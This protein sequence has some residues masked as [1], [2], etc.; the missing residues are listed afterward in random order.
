MW[1]T[2]KE[3]VELLQTNHV[4]VKLKLKNH[5][6][7]PNIF[8]SIMSIFKA[9]TEE[10]MEYVWCDVVEWKQG[11]GLDYKVRCLPV[12]NGFYAKDF[13]TCDL[14]SLINVEKVEFRLLRGR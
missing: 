9:S 10:N 8:K 12:R 7:K 13:Y 2:D 4:Q 5:M 3:F 1:F 14:V 11:F 6:Y